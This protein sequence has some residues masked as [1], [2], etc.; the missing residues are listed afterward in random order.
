MMRR[1]QSKDE[2]ELWGAS[3]G[4]VTELLKISRKGAYIIGVNV[5]AESPELGL[6]QLTFKLRL[7][8]IAY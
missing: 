5:G 3:I 4:K 2:G 7:N 8:K 6:P 1:A